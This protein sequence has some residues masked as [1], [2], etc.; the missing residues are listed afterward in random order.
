MSLKMTS[1]FFFSSHLRV[2]SETLGPKN[3]SNLLLEVT[4]VTF[5]VTAAIKATNISAEHARQ[6]AVY[7]LYYLAL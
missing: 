5:T 4:I 6:V 3:S 7:I 1:T 2:L